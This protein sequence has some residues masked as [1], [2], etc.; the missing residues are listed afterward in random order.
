MPEQEEGWEVK[1][2]SR[3][4]DDL[5]DLDDF[6]KDAEGN[7]SAGQENIVKKTTDRKKTFRNVIISHFPLTNSPFIFATIMSSK[8]LSGFEVSGP[9]RIQLRSQKIKLTS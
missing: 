7:E 8:A 5:K 3:I 6:W 9:P 2:G 1:A 4:E